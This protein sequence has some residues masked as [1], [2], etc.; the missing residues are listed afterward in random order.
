MGIVGRIP[1]RRLLAEAVASALGG[2]PSALFVHGEAGVGKTRLVEEACRDAEGLG[3]SVLWGR[4]VRFGAA[5]SP[6]APIVGALRSWLDTHP[7]SPAAAGADLA[8]LDALLPALVART[9]DGTGRLLPLIDS[10]LSRIAGRGPVV[11]VVDD[12]QW[13]DVSTLDLLGYLVAGF[14]SQRLVLLGTCRDEDVGIGHPVH[15]WLADLRRLPSVSEVFLGRLSIDETREQIEAVSRAAADHHLV[16]QVFER[17]AGN[18]YLTE[19]LVK[20]LPAGGRD[21]S[22]DVSVEL[23]EALMARW[24]QLTETA[25]EVVRV[26]AVA[27]RPFGVAVIARVA[28][29]QGIPAEAIAP[30]LT[31]AVGLGVL[32]LVDRDR[33]WFWHPLLAEVLYDSMIP[34]QTKR[35]HEEFASVLQSETST[36]VEEGRRFADLALHHEGAGDPSRAFAALLRAA[37]IAADLKA[38]PEESHH[39]RRAVEMWDLVGGAAHRRAG[40]RLAL[41]ERAAAAAD[42]ALDGPTWR[43]MLDRALTLVDP[44]ASPLETARV[45]GAWC[46]S[47]SIP[48]GRDDDGRVQ[49]AVRLSAGHP[50]SPEHAIALARR[51]EVATWW[52]EPTRGRDISERAVAA[53]ERS[54]SMEALTLALS[55]RAFTNIPRDSALIDGR[56]SFRLAQLSGRLDLI[57]PVTMTLAN[58]FLGRGMLPEVVEVCVAGIEAAQ[59]AGSSGAG[60]AAFAA[61]WFLELGDLPR[62]QETLRLA[63]GS[64]LVGPSGAATRLCAAEFAIRGG[65]PEAAHA[66]LL[67]AEEILPDIESFVGVGAPVTIAEHHLACGN[68]TEA[69]AVLER[70]MVAQ[71]VDLEWVDGMLLWAARAA[72]DLAERARDRRDR[73]G[74]SAAEQHLARLVAFRESLSG[75]AFA[76]AGPDDVY[77]PALSAIFLAESARCRGETTS[78]LWRTAADACSTGGLRWNEAVCLWRLGQALV[79]SG[80]ERV[81]AAAALR[82]AHAMAVDFGA[83]P[84]RAEVEAVAT[85]ARI[86]LEPPVLPEQTSQGRPAIDGLTRREL[87]VLAHLVAGRSNAEIARDLFISDKTVSVHVSNLLRKTGTSS[88]REAAALARRNGLR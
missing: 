81:D 73:D 27:G 48:P 41:L 4:C 80:G 70:G 35:M 42:R 2:Q 36:Q 31:E 82:A 29:Q 88:R 85:A 15:G 57:D 45:I 53:A 59:R 44:E 49:E 65:N 8:G 12:V 46:E 25:R 23:R 78:D 84:L 37:D 69:L 77:R 17:S 71:Q 63:L 58:V 32:E 14:R 21:L 79:N 68:P 33:Y 34:A 86:S 5:T 75:A 1:E 40:S 56:E 61:G 13:A 67:R 76:V 9:P 51:A 64:R 50:D 62:C 30:S 43:E 19:L 3:F 18:A 47:R 66:H 52:G 39:L 83:E 22:P 54:G 11:L 87:E 24:H 6:F 60:I 74:A 10:A 72:A 20:E 38:F 16:A 7:V 28:Q 55:A 26:L